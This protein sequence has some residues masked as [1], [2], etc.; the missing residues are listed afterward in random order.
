MG[1]SSI[2]MCGKNVYDFPHLFLFSTEF[3]QNVESSIFISVLRKNTTKG[4]I[5]S[6]CILYKI[7]LGRDHSIGTIGHCS[8]HLAEHLCTDIS[9]SKNPRRTGNAFL[10]C[11]NISGLIQGYQLSQPLGIGNN[12]HSNKYAICMDH[13]FL[14][15]LHI[16]KLHSCHL[17]CSLYFHS[18]R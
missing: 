15:C 11:N 14:S 6:L 7:F 4:A 1:F 17:L 10:S 2:L 13:S 12:P 18:P 8:Y 5:G 9:C 3:V 16:G